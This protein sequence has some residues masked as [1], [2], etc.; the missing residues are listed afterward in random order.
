MGPDI[1]YRVV[2][3]G[4][5]GSESEIGEGKDNFPRPKMKKKSIRGLGI[6]T[7]SV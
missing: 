5:S 3:E 4:S 1:V 6:K 2:K 7:L